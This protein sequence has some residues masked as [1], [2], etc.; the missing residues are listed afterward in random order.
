MNFENQFGKDLR[1]KLR[2]VI[3]SAPPQA[4][5]PVQ[6]AVVL[7]L[8][9][10]SD[11]IELLLIKRAE[12]ARD[13]WSGHIALPGGRAEPTD[14]NLIA[15]AIRETREEVGIDLITD[16]EVLGH[17]EPLFPSSPRLPRILVTPVV[18][19]V[20]SSV[21]ATAGSEV[22]VA[23]WVAV[24]QLKREGRSETVDKVFEGETYTW[25]GYPSPYGPVWGI[26]ERL[27]TRFLTLWG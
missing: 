5:W 21:V 25:P 17:F 11:E 2:P 27:L 24:N 15:T 4:D 19:V 9:E 7:I 20:N 26:T 14:E 8:R 23:F 16:G 6:A 18:A 3:Q 10:I 13:P 12:D 1:E 22:E